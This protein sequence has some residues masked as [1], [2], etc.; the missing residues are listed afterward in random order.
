MASMRMVDG[1]P[2]AKIEIIVTL[3]Q[4]IFHFNNTGSSP[5]Y[6]LTKNTFL[7]ELIFLL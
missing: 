1:L 6:K 4:Y 5:T 3:N 2:F 7:S